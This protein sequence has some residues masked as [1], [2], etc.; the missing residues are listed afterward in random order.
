MKN[1][2]IWTLSVLAFISF[3]QVSADDSAPLYEAKII[4]NFD[5][6]GSAKYPVGSMSPANHLLL[7]AKTDGK[8]D[9]KE[10]N[11][12]QYMD[13]SGKPVVWRTNK[14]RYATE[15][16]PKIRYI[17]KSWPIDLFGVNPKNV[18]TLQ[19][20][21]VRVKFDR[22]GNNFFSIQ[23]GFMDNGKWTEAALPLSQIDNPGIVKNLSMWVWGA[24]FNY[25]IEVSIR[26][27]RGMTHTLFLSPADKS[28]K[29][30]PGNLN[31]I[32]WKQLSVDIPASISQNSPYAT[33]DSRLKLVQFVIRTAPDER[34]DDYYVYFDNLRILVDLHSSFFDGNDLVRPQRIQELG[35]SEDNKQQDSSA[36]NKPAE[37][38][39]SEQ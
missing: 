30:R 18:D 34:V 15:G 17:P 26:D 28:S 10:S 29:L 36:N 19:T 5:G 12:S 23:P 16:F 21:G 35:N 38:A 14:S 9:K 2:A 32:G 24:G 1:I 7:T 22:L 20:L 25:T 11:L 8:E 31:F 13:I 4:D 37:E 27:Y 3:V 39:K 6:E 33:Q